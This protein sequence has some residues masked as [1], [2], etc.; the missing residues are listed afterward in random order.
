VPA[1][2]AKTARPPRHLLVATGLALLLVAQSA[3]VTAASASSASSASGARDPVAS[4]PSAG[5]EP[6]IHWQQARAHEDDAIAFTPGRRVSIGFTP[7]ATDRW[8]VGGVKPRSLPAGRLDGASIREQG[9]TRDR[10]DP[11][12]TSPRPSVD[13]PSA[14]SS[15]GAGPTF[16]PQARV[17][18]GALK[19]EIFG[20]LPYWQLNSS[21][22]RIQY[23]KISTIAYFGVGADAKATSSSATATGRSRRAGPAGRARG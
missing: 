13:R 17:D 4:A 5:L 12:G 18:P 3:P 11:K 21:S 9:V 6:T 2:P 1:T 16:A 7:R 8:I 15:P 19:R 23:D 14:S 22:L 10:S 20:F